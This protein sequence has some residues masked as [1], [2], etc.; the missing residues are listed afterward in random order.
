MATAGRARPI[1]HR[2]PWVPARSTCSAG[3]RRHRCCQHSCLRVLPLPRSTPMR[4]CC[5]GTTSARTATRCTTARTWATKA[6]ALRLDG[7]QRNATP[8]LRVPALHNSPRRR[9]PP[10]RTSASRRAPR[11][12]CLRP[13]SSSRRR[14]PATPAVPSSSRPPTS[15][16]LRSCRMPASPTVLLLCPPSITVA[17]STSLCCA[18]RYS[19]LRLARSHQ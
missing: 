9:P 11:T 4:R 5:T 15:L 19:R 12:A 8:R 2:L 10:P 18:R 17:P 3:T 6:C 13:C 7:G 16:P 1:H 14:R